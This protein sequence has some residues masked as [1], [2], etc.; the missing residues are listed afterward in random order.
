MTTYSSSRGAAL[1]RAYHHWRER[2]ALFD[3]SASK[4]TVPA[5]TIAISRE[6]GAGGGTIAHAIA[7]QLGWP[8]Y[9]RELVDKIAADS[10]VRAQ[11]VEQL[12][13]KRPNWI[14]EC[15]QAFSAEK[16]MNGA[17]FAIRLR[18][19]LLALYC[20]GNC[21]IL[22]RGAAQVL[23]EKRTLRI[24]LIA[25]QLYRVQR[26]T[27][28]LGISQEAERH[29]AEIDRQRAQ[30]VKTYFLR[31][32]SHVHDYDLTIDTSRFSTTECRDLILLAL[33]ARQSRVKS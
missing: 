10:G 5:V 18:D 30:F 4:E 27:D 3:L 7:D 11:L 31:D 13:E 25:P 9:D 20:H 2:G 1:E 12:D 32:P 23:P 29:V 21:V 17:S 33:Q 26:A 8:V 14:D 19:T 24:R 6:R 15:L 16:Q 22:G 28:H